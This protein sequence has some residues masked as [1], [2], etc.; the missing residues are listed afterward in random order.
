MNNLIDSSGPRGKDVQNEEIVCCMR[1]CM[2][3]FCN[4]RSFTID[5]QCL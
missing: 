4:L 1:E 3:I 5:I 2:N